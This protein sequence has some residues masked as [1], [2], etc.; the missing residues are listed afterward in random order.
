M[1]HTLQ[2]AGLKACTQHTLQQAGLEACTQHTLQRSACQQSPHPIEQV[3]EGPASRK[4]EHTVP[5]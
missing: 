1:Q 2:Q 5:N 3:I 4:Q